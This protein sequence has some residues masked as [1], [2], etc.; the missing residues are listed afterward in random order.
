MMDEKCFGLGKAGDCCV[1]CMERCHG[2]EQCGFYKPPWRF[3]R[4]Q[5]LANVR[6]RTLPPAQ[7]VHIA[8]KYHGGHMPW[9][10]GARV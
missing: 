3:K 10:K 2:Y 9:K 1:L 8:E 4:D 6:L 5:E 7:Q